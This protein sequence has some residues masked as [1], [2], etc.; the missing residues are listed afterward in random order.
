[1]HINAVM[2]KNM[3][4]KEHSAY[5][6]SLWETAFHRNAAFHRPCTYAE[7]SLCYDPNY[8]ILIIKMN[9]DVIIKVPV[10]ERQRFYETL[11]LI[12]WA[13][14]YVEWSLHSYPNCWILTSEMITDVA[15]KIHHNQCWDIGFIQTVT[16]IRQNVFIKREAPLS[17]NR[18]HWCPD[19]SKYHLCKF[20]KWLQAASPIFRYFHRCDIIGWIS[21]ISL[22]SMPFPD[23][24][25]VVSI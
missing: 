17:V 5:G 23:D 3:L 13:Q 9:T 10:N 8:S 20:W 6:P 4:C 1:M 14:G 12:G 24:L 16:T 19:V 15:I 2:N 25:N 22:V 18:G 21:H 11:S 7:W